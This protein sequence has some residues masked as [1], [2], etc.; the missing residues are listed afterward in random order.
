[1][2]QK[3]PDRG[4]FVENNFDTIIWDLEEGQLPGL[5]EFVEQVIVVHA[6]ADTRF[7]GNPAGVLINYPDPNPTEI[8]AL[9][10]YMDLPVIST[11]D[12]IDDSIYSI[13]WFTKN[14]ELALCGHGTMTA[15][16]AIFKN[17]SPD[18]ARIS[19]E[20]RLSGTLIAELNAGLITLT[21]PSLQSP[22][23]HD[24]GENTAVQKILNAPIDHIRQAEDAWSQCL[25][26]TLI[27]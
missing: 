11:L 26:M 19:F 17:S 24:E 27:L 13:R 6:F 4:S 9:A 15:C 7:D 5:K 18:L 1:M 3:F 16:Y 12:R 23:V 21:L 20:N 2:R 22:R 8:A 25:K 10:S 14:A